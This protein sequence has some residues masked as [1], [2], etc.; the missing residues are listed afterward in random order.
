MREVL[1]KLYV[2]R[3][4]PLT[5]APLQLFATVV[6]YDS[7]ESVIRLHFSYVYIKKKKKKILSVRLCDLWSR[8]ASRISLYLVAFILLSILTSL[9][10]C[11]FLSQGDQIIVFPMLSE[12][13]LNTKLCAGFCLTYLRLCRKGLV[14]GVLRDGCTCGRF[15]G[16]LSVGSKIHLKCAKSMRV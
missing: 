11:C 4:T 3:H 15:L 13:S 1:H 14:D 5:K 7:T 9:C 2:K 6:S 16:F 8:F 12:F 10:P